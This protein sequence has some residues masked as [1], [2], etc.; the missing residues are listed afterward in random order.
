MLHSL[1][2]LSESQTDSFSSVSKTEG[3]SL[4]LVVRISYGHRKSFT[5][6]YILYAPCLPPLPSSSVWSHTEASGNKHHV[7]LKRLSKYKY[8][9]GSSLGTEHRRRA[10]RQ[11]APQQGRAEAPR[12]S[13]G[14]G[15][16]ITLK[17]LSQPLSHSLQRTL[18]EHLSSEGIPQ[19]HSGKKK[20]SL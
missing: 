19:I 5:K 2:L 6:Q 12:A 1:V 4:C 11:K 8:V 17:I 16:P 14:P 15:A 10:G 9:R 18:F 3:Q 7:Q 20:R 13:P